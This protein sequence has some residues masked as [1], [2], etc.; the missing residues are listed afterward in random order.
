MVNQC[1]NHCFK[2]FDCDI[3]TW[4]TLQRNSKIATA[5]NSAKH[6]RSASSQQPTR[7]HSPCELFFTNFLTTQKCLVETTM[8][9]ASV[10]ENKHAPTCCS[11]RKIYSHSMCD[12]SIS[13]HSSKVWR[14]ASNQL[15]RR[16]NPSSNRRIKEK[17][18]LGATHHYVKDVTSL[19]L[20][21]PIQAFLRSRATSPLNTRQPALSTNSCLTHFPLQ[22]ALFTHSRSSEY[23]STLLGTRGPIA[24][25]KPAVRL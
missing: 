8:T 1:S 9:D 25:N 11:S 6:V 2:P 21:R 3:F 24:T 12:F 4:F 7:I 16:P 23:L 13:R 22:I 5:Y 19:M 15:H 20:R 10:S 17:T 18:K 14:I